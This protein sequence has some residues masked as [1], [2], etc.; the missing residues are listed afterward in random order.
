M[1]P[2]TY[3]IYSLVLLML[4]AFGLA[5]CDSG[6]DTTPGEL[7]IEDLTPGTGMEA[8]NG[9]LLSVHYTGRLDDGT[10]FDSS[11]P[12][13]EPF[14]FVLG[15]GTVIKGWDQG[16]LGMKQGGTRKLTIPPELGYGKQGIPGAIPGNAT[17]T[18]D[19]ELLQVTRP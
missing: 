14:A 6:D 13:G 9:D 1:K 19:V 16:L 18:F 8:Q 11:I 3:R 17:L 7:V 15:A 5:G 2:H 12:R 4:G 10:V